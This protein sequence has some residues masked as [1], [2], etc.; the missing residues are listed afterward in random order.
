MRIALKTGLALVAL[1]ALSIQSFGGDTI[2][3]WDQQRKGTNFFS[4]QPLV[5]RF[6]E[7]KAAGVSWGRLAYDKWDGAERDFLIGNADQYDGLVE[8]DMARL[9]EVLGWA[10]DAGLGMVIAPLT[11]PGARWQQNNDGKFDNRLWE[12]KAYWQQSADFWRDLAARLR[13][14]PAVVAYNIVNEPAPERGTGAAENTV[15]GDTAS[16]VAWYAEHKGTARDL[17]AFYEMVIA[18]IR[19]VDPDTPIMVDSGWYANAGTFSAWPTALSDDKVLYAF[20]MYEPYNFT[21]GKNFREELGYVYPG[22]VPFGEGEVAWDAGTVNAFLQPVYAWAAKQ[23]LPP[24]RIVGAEFGCM[25]RN[26]GCAAY[27]TDVMANFNAHDIHWAFY[28]FREDEYDGFDYE[29]GSDALGWKYWEAVEKGETP[30]MP[31]KDN[32]LW[33]AIQ[34]GLKE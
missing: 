12:D 30:V 11:L 3:F 20:H 31:Y 33:D 7:A 24:S 13:D 21:A 29:L 34:A 15:P 27:L 10:H 5:E 26:E 14:N 4:V 32:P 17:P 28:S 8:P 16:F 2:A 22:T 19:S 25:R 1:G 23:G 9:E 18:A 6:M